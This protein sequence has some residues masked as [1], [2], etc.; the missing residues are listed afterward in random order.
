MPEGTKPNNNNKNPKGKG[1]GI[2]CTIFGACLTCAQEEA[3]K[4][5]TAKIMGAADLIEATKFSALETEVTKT[6][7]EA[8]WKISAAF[9]VHNGQL[10]VE[11]TFLKDELN[12]EREKNRKLLGKLNLL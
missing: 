8:G 9:S 3:L 2:L 10:E 11:K 4:S 1:K 7:L 12:S 6:A 5:D